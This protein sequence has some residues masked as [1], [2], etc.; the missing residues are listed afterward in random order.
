MPVRSS[1]SSTGPCRSA[2]Q[3][4]ALQ[5]RQFSSSAGGHVTRRHS[6]STFSSGRVAIARQA[7]RAGRCLRRV[8]HPLFQAHRL[9]RP[10]SSS[11]TFLLRSST[12]TA[13]SLRL[14]V[15]AQF[16][17]Q[18]TLTFLELVERFSVCGIGSRSAGSFSAHRRV[19]LARSPVGVGGNL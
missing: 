16:L 13:S 4:I 11:F 18:L 17:A 7:D 8:G 9:P 6:L 2:S 19:A 5:L 10:A 15:A 1:A 14:G 12:D 3:H